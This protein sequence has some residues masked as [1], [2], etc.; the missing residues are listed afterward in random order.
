MENREFR[1]P[2]ADELNRDQIYVRDLP[3]DGVHLIVGGPGTGKSVMTLLRAGRLERAKKDYIYLAYNKLLI[4]SSVQMT[5]SFLKEG[6]KIAQWQS[7]FCQYV[8][9]YL[10]L[11][12][13]PTKEGASSKFDWDWQAVLA[14][15]DSLPFEKLEI[16]D[17]P[18]LIIDEGQDMP[19]EFYRALISI[20]F[21]NFYIAAD[22][23]QQIT[24][25]NSSIKDL[26]DEFSLE[27]DEVNY[28]SM[29]YRNTSRIA[30][31]ANEFYTDEASN[32]PEIPDRDNELI[33]VL[34][35]YHNP[36]LI[37]QKILNTMTLDKS[38]LAGVI[39]PNNKIREQFYKHL[40]NNEK[41]ILVRTYA[42]GIQESLN[43]NQGGIIVINGQSCKGLEFDYVFLGDVNKYY[44]NP[45]DPKIVSDSK[46]LFYVMTSRPK[47]QL[48]LLQH[49]EES[50]IK[51][52][53]PDN[54]NILR[55]VTGY[56]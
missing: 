39:C 15:I 4:Q 11:D 24:E 7:W 29:N 37:Y 28:I 48:I 49:G 52:I 40:K 41:G 16:A 31:L 12:N 36:E 14:H 27:A 53:L 54:E 23:N 51:S 56:E 55:K 46:K 3:L 10:D 45:N 19:P 17:K 50:H 22:Q 18:Y 42:H 35:T 38:K 34:Y 47:E 33:P 26:K 8:R 43:F 9:Q 13:I 1:L 25:R 5:Q 20:G 30:K 44:F 32:K 6:L 2:D 21:E